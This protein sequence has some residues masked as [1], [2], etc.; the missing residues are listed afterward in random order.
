VTL[1]GNILL[2]AYSIAVLL[3]ILVYSGLNTGRK[4]RSYRLFMS[5]VYFM[6]A[7]L[8]SD[9]MGR[10]D[11]RPGTFYEPVNRIGNFLD[12]IL[13]PIVPSIW[14]LY[15]ISQ[16][17]YSR[18]WFNRV[19]IFLIGIFT[20]QAVMTVVSL[21]TGWYY[22][23]GEDNIYHRG[24]LFFIPL[25]IPLLL[26]LAAEMLVIFR[27]WRIS[28]KQLF[29]LLFF[30]VLPLIAILLSSLIYGV[31]LIMNGATLSILIVF[32]NIQTRSI[33]TDYLT[34]LYNRQKMESALRARV[35]NSSSRDSF[36]AIL[37]DLDGFKC[38]NDTYGHLVG[39]RALVEA[40]DLLRSCFRP[41]DFVARYGGDEFFLLF[42]AA[43]DAVLRDAVT[44]IEKAAEV[45]NQNSQEPYRLSF[46]MGY[47][48]YE[49]R[50]RLDADA[51]LRQLDTMLYVKK[52]EKKEQRL[53]IEK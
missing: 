18:K 34:G 22:R 26:I 14:I 8:V 7:M 15:V 12:F 53:E 23:I 6:I 49:Y 16:T 21:W 43:N 28:N 10:F 35:N 44:R 29:S 32:F 37:I 1:T 9:I 48:L 27:R 38:I 33:N 31:S 17:G 50:Y 5:A 20:A 11:G 42:D 45:A 51:F 41:G 47:A 25:L 46:S 40:A 13:N 36:A 24:P 30:P 2:N 19:K 39:D 52:R 3:Y 4:D